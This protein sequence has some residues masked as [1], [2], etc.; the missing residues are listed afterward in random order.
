MSQKACMQVNVP[1][2]TRQIT[3]PRHFAAPSLGCLVFKMGWCYFPHM[4]KCL[5]NFKALPIE[6]M[7]EPEEAAEEEKCKEERNKE[8]EKWELWRIKKESFPGHK[9]IVQNTS[10]LVPR[11]ALLSRPPLPT[12]QGPC[13]TVQPWAKHF[14]EPPLPHLYNGVKDSSCH[15]GLL[16]GSNGLIRLGGYAVINIVS[17]TN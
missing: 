16:W 3:L 15:I 4:G 11:A 10:S 17:I 14:C 9:M 7:F 8:A 5:V 13:P 2:L 1:P 6:G 12:R